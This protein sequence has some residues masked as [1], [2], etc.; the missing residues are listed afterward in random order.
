M[1]NIPEVTERIVNLESVTEFDPKMENTD[2]EILSDEV[3]EFKADPNAWLPVFLLVGCMATALGILISV[4]LHSDLT[5]KYGVAG[6]AAIEFLFA[7]CAAFCFW[8]VLSHPPPN[9]HRRSIG[10]SSKG[11]VSLDPKR[12]T[13]FIQWSQITALRNRPILERIEL[14]DHTGN[15]VLRIEFQTER[16]P[17]LLKILVHNVGCSRD[18]MEIPITIHKPM[19]VSQIAL[20]VL[21]GAICVLLGVLMILSHSG[22]NAPN[23]A[24]AVLFMTLPI[25]A[26]ALEGM[27]RIRAIAIDESGIELK[28]GMKSRRIEIKDINSVNVHC[29]NFGNGKS[30]LEVVAQMKSGNSIPIC[31][32]GTYVF[33]IYFAMNTA[34]NVTK[35]SQ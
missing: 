16:F 7:G 26:F 2:L 30:I 10:V 12:P 4:F 1:V 25:M 24:F 20:R 29:R 14:L 23:A 27:T 8:K 32:S 22:R 18:E 15:S 5:L 11:I 13:P 34:L 19:P 17:E 33:D 6:F 31:R 3:V 28:T 9:S 35:R 21:I